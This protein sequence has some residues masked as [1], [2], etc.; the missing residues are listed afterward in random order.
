VASKSKMG[1]GQSVVEL[2]ESGNFQKDWVVAWRF[3]EARGNLWVGQKLE[4]A[5]SMVGHLT[6][7]KTDSKLVAAGNMPGLG[8]CNEY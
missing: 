5:A 2:V 3:V 6:F 7:G 8:C 1:G 4:A